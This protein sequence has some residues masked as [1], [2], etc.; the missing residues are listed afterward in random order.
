MQTAVTLRAQTR[1]RDAK[2]RV[3]SASDL[4]QVEVSRPFRQAVRLRM[5]CANTCNANLIDA[6][7]VTTP[8]HFLTYMHACLTTHINLICIISMYMHM[9]FTKVKNYLRSD[10][11]RVGDLKITL[12]PDAHLTISTTHVQ[13]FVMQML[14]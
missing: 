5:R 12:L 2:I 6:D 3:R 4:R 8:H 11:C 9:N 7:V 10:C 14:H 1:R 13:K